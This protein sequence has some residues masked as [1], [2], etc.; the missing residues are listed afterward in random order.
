MKRLEIF[1]ATPS[2]YTQKM[3]SL[4]R[5]KRILNIHWGDT[6]GRLESLNLELPK[7]VLLPVILFE[8]EEKEF[9]ATTDSTPMIERLENEYSDRKV[10]PDDPALAFINYL[11]KILEMNGLLN[12]CFITGGTAMLMLTK[13]ALFCL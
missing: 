13:Q 2:P 10:I 8:N 1:G 4:L 7:P 6:R 12:I 5:Y 11:L 3:L 9:T